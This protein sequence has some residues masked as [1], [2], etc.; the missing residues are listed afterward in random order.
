MV[1]EWRYPSI[2]NKPIESNSVPTCEPPQIIRRGEEEEREGGKGKTLE[3]GKG[4]RKSLT[5]QT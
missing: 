1:L 5:R 2:P 3:G 4:K